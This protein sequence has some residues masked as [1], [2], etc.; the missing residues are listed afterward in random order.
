MQKD[1]INKSDNDLTPSQEELDAL[2]R[3]MP[4]FGPQGVRQTLEQKSKRF[5]NAWLLLMVLTITYT[6]G[7]FSG[8]LQPYMAAGVTGENADYQIH[9]IRFLIGFLM[10]IVGSIAINFNW[11]LERV[12]TVIAW[13]QTYFIFSGVIRQWRTL[14]DDR[15]FVIGAYSLNLLVILGLILILIFEERRLNRS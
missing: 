13:V 6:M 14:P 1:P 11:Q 9:Q 8:L 7:W 15:L 10:L 2:L 12:F 4:A 3:D 5:K